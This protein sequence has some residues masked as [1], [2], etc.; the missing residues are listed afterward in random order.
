MKKNLLIII[1]TMVI[2]ATVGTAYSTVNGYFSGYPIVNIKVDGIDVKGDTPAINFNG[3]TMV[4]LGFVGKALGANIAWDAANETALIST[5]G[6][7]ASSEDIARLKLFS[8]ISSK[9]MEL[10]L[11]G[12][13][14]IN[15]NDA[16][17][18]AG[19]MYLPEQSLIAYNQGLTEFHAIQDSYNDI[20][21]RNNSIVADASNAGLDIST[22]ISILNSYELA[23]EYY[24]KAYS[25]YDT[26]KSFNSHVAFNSMME[27]K[28]KGFEISLQARTDANTEGI[29]YFNLIQNY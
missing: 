5:G 1:V 9:Y 26:W 10:G 3:R 27:N 11:L 28:R 16:L 14:L 2:L 6:T 24:S 19:T 18:L 20:R 21:K 4:P 29:R 13:R 22:T 7:V 12:E 25:D 17:Y 8:R 23:I 15:V